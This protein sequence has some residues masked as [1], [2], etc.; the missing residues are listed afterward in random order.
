MPVI[1]HELLISAPIEKIHDALTNI[2]G[3]SAWWTAAEFI[4]NN[5][6]F[7]FGGK[8]FK[9]MEISAND[10]RHVQ[11]HCVAG[12]NEWIGTTLSFTFDSQTKEELL[13]HHPEIAGQTEQQ[14]G[15]TI[16][17]LRFTHDNWRDHTPMFA[18]CNY[19]WAIFLRSLKLYCETGF[20]KP[21][22]NQHK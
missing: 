18:E 10:D 1:C 16:T 8:Y 7:H 6:R 14:T 11:W 21:Y 13:A 2:Q 20:G 15:E 12:A 22:L 19:T 3:L 9:E 4:E 17:F 5:I